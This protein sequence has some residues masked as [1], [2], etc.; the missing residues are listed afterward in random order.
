MESP[1]IKDPTVTQ[2]LKAISSESALHIIKSL[3]SSSNKSDSSSLMEQLRLSKKQFYIAISHLSN[4]GIV[5]KRTE[6][7]GLLMAYGIP[8]TE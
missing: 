6:S 7:I 4:Q 2:T 5:K 1:K 3:G 8:L